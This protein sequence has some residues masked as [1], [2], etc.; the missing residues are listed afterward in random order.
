[1]IRQEELLYK[2]RK[3]KME[4]EIL[5]IDLTNINRELRTFN[6]IV[7]LYKEEN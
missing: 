2:L 1:M 7:A 4:L 3:L 6:K 5:E